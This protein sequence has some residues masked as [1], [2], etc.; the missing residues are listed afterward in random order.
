MRRLRRAVRAALRAWR[1]DEGFAALFADEGGHFFRAPAFEREDAE[2][3]EEAWTFM[4][5]EELQE[6]L[7]EH[8]RNLDMGNMADVRKEHE[9]RTGDGVGDVFRERGEV[10]A[11][12][13]TPSHRR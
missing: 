13:A 10:S 6:F 11:P 4:L 9:L 2:T 12:A 5:L 3:V 1:R 8:L 7:V